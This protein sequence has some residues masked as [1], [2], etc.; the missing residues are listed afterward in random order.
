MRLIFTLPLVMLAACN[1]DNDSAN[2]QMTLE[3]NQERIEDAASDVANTASE[4]G[5]SIANV[6]ESTG[7]AIGNEVGDIDIDV[8]VNRNRSGNTQYAGAFCR[9]LRNRPERADSDGPGGRGALRPA[10]PPQLEAVAFS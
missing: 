8:D 10:L 9:Y 7:E 6:A 1:V 5:S 2:D 3:Y 4:L